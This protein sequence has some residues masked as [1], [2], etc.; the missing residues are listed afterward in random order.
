MLNKKLVTYLLLLSWLVIS[1]AGLYLFSAA[2]IVSFDPQNSLMISAMD[3]DFDQRVRSIFFEQYGAL[4]KSAFHIRDPECV[5]DSLA[6]G[7]IRALDSRFSQ[8]N[9]AIHAI[10]PAGNDALKS[11]IPSTPALAV[12][13]VNGELSYLGPYSSGFFCSSSTSLIEPIV[14][15]ITENK[16][17]GAIVI[18]QSE[19]CYCAV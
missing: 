4:Y 16:H 7:H 11:V 2:R 3:K 6:E 8:Y 17:L 18:S 10:S 13:D 12:F 5:C 19:G 14:N 15:N 9:F 1:L